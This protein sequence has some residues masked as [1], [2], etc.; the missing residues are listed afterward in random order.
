MELNAFA[1]EEGVGLP[2]LGNVPAVRQVRNDGLAAVAR[3]TPDKI[4]E[5]ATH[6]AEVVVGARLVQIEVRYPIGDAHAEYG[7]VFGAGIRCSELERSTVE[8][9]R[10]V[11]Q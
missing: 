9:I 6:R 11:C 4:V 5:H 2:V 8:L 3:I 1:Q 7:P 10:N